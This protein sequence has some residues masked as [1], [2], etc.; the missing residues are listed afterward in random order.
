MYWQ[1]EM[2][3]KDTQLQ[4]KDDQLQ[5]KDSQLQYLGTELTLAQSQLHQLQVS[6]TYGIG[7]HFELM[8]TTHCVCRQRWML[9]V[10]RLNSNSKTEMLKLA[11]CREI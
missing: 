11:D 2:E 9:E 10:L 3:A 7:I 5:Q 1:E 6:Y 8:H 4:L